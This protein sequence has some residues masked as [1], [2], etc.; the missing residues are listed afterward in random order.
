MDKAALE[1]DLLSLSKML[2]KVIE[3][4]LNSDTYYTVR[5]DSKDCEKN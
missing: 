5:A 2:Y 1:Q 4:D 3:V